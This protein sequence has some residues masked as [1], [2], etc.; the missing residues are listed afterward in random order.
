M[1]FEANK[2]YLLTV[3]QNDFYQFN[4]GV[5]R[6][7]LF[8]ILRPLIWYERFEALSQGKQP[9]YFTASESDIEKERAAALNALRES[10]KSFILGNRTSPNLGYVLKSK[11]TQ[12]PDPYFYY[13]T[14]PKG[15][16]LFFKKPSGRLN[17]SVTT[18]KQTYQPGD[19]VNFEITVD[20]VNET[21]GVWVSALASDESVK[22]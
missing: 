21:Q 10:P 11:R 3:D 6:V 8:R 16:L 14:I 7:Q 4:G 19:M 17:V 15:E 20:P 12:L 9:Y 2:S 1:S 18:D 13:F 5:L 22:R